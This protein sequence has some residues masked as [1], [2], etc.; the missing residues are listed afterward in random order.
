MHAQS[1]ADHDWEINLPS[2]RIG[3]KFCVRKGLLSGVVQEVR[4]FEEANGLEFRVAHYK[5]CRQSI[6]I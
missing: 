1:I 2:Y 5:P 3:S 4:A 6:V